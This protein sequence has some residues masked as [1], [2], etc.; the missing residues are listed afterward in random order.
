MGRRSPTRWVLQWPAW[1]CVGVGRKRGLRRSYTRRKRQQG[2]GGARGSA[3]RGVGHDGRGGRSSGDRAAPR[4]ELLH[5]WGEGG[6]GRRPASKK[7]TAARQ[8]REG[9]NA[10]ALPA[11]EWMHGRTE[12]WWRARTMTMQCSRTGAAH[13]ASDR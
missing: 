13:A 2:G 4:G 9:G 10:M 12:R 6:E 8:R 5:K 1:S 11:E 7:N 3:H